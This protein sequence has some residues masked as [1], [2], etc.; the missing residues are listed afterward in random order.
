MDQ[1]P[2]TLDR[3][4]IFFGLLAAAL[5]AFI[6]LSALGILVPSRATEGERWIGGIAGLVFVLG[7]IAVVLQT[8][9]ANGPSPEGDL[10]SGTPL[11]LRA[12]YYIIVLTVV[13]SLATIATWVAFGPGER[14]F[15]GNLVMPQWLN[16]TA[17]RALFGF[18]A[19]LC[20]LILFAMAAAS[21]NRLRGR[22]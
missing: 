10:P 8:W 21:F 14:Q 1:Q 13:A 4:N 11:W 6:M 9:A 7:G 17:G 16:E 5:G 22:K 3:S 15:T 2:R 20:W 18:G 19:I 12:V